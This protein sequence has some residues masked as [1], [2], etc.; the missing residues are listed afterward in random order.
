MVK[1]SIVIPSLNSKMYIRKTIE[2]VLQQTLKDIEIICV[3]AGSVDGTLDIL[4]KYAKNDSRIRIIHS[5]KKSYGYQMNLGFKLAQGEYIGIVESDDFASPDMFE[6]LYTAAKQD[7]LDLVKSGFFNHHTKADGKSY[8]LPV[9][10]PSEAPKEIFHP[11]MSSFTESQQFF[12]MSP[13]IWTGLYN[14]KFLRENRIVFTETPGA[15][16]QD[17]AFTFKVWCCAKRV[18]FINECLLHYRR[19]NEESSSNS[20]GKIYCIMDEYREEEHFISVEHPQLKEKAEGIRCRLKFAAYIWNYKRLSMPEKMDFLNCASKEFLDDFSKKYFVKRYFTD[21]QWNELQCITENP[22][23]YHEIMDNAVD[24]ADKNAALQ[25]VISFS[26]KRREIENL[27]SFQNIILNHVENPLISV[28]IP[29]YNTAD[30]ISQCIQSIQDQSLKNLE[31]LCVDDGSSDYSLAILKEIAEH[32]DRISII[33]SPKN[34]GQSIARNRGAGLAKGRYIYFMDSDDLLGKEALHELVERM[35]KDTLDIIYFDADSFGDGADNQLVERYS[36]YYHR[37]GTYE[38]IYTGAELMSLMERNHEYRMSP[39]LQV[40]RRSFYRTNQLTFPEGII[41]EDNVFTFISMLLAKK[42]GYANQSYYNRRVR[43]NSTM[44]RKTS[45]DNAYGYFKCYLEMIG[46]LKSYHGTINNEM[47]S[48]MASVYTNGRN[49][50]NNL[51]WEERS[52]RW[53]LPAIEETQ[54]NLYYEN[55]TDI[56]RL[57]KNQEQLEHL[58]FDYSSMQNSLSFRI[59]RIITWLPRKCRGG[60]RCYQEHGINYT[61]KRCF[62]HLGIK[63][64]TKDC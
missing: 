55:S 43:P 39:C 8:D 41:H 19:D 14:A 10:I 30:Y 16:Y 53:A 45:W 58:K 64:G 12:T 60:I 63:M 32:D 6:K 4:H 40:I 54:M 38:N 24:T 33:H 52:I 37:S 28:V 5:E 27:D 22:K 31:I 36:N 17:T 23:A 15:S 18:K 56:N 46:F 44:T 11:L 25:N 29:V 2:S 57:K 20:K 26:K 42:V 13:S 61:M 59:G 48:I 3:D 34:N 62:E 49:A 7:N 1:V 47:C 9:F 51:S 50:Y 21:T 35:E